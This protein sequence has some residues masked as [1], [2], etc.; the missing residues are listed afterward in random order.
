MKGN[1]I[2]LKEYQYEE[3]DM[4]IIKLSKKYKCYNDECSMAGCKGHKFTLEF[5]TVTDGISFND[6]QRET[7]F[8][9]PPQLNCLI[10]LLKELDELRAD[11]PVHF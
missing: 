5:D 8:I 6:G 4:S 9:Q 2:E 1:L 10:D 11:A 3:Q 7:V